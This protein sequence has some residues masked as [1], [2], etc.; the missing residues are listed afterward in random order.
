MKIKRRP[1]RRDSNNNIV[2]EPET[3][4]PMTRFFRPKQ[5][6][7]GVRWVKSHVKYPIKLHPD[8]EVVETIFLPVAFNPNFGEEEITPEGRTLLEQRK[9]ELRKGE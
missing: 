4:N 9:A 5:R 1:M 6:W 7:D 2:P 3:N 8:G